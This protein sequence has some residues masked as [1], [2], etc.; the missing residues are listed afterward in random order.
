ME[1]REI[2]YKVLDWFKLA[3]NR[4]EWQASENMWII[5]EIP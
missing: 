3:Q 4:L 5:F 2:V 1:L